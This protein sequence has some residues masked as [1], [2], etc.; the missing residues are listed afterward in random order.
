MGD[1]GM[2]LKGTGM[3]RKDQIIN[4][5]L[6]KRFSFPC[7]SGCLRHSGVK[8]LFLSR[9]LIHTR[10]QIM[11]YGNLSAEGKNFPGSECLET[12]SREGLRL[13]QFTAGNCWSPGNNAECTNH[14]T[15]WSLL[16]SHS[17]WQRRLWSP[18][19]TSLHL[20]HAGMPQPL[21]PFYFFFPPS[22]SCF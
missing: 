10:C 13:A 2:K 3:Q 8:G 20:R 7:S 17:F 6:Y 16:E 4:A 15:S 19:L 22:P 14:E 9:P 11:K 5:A 18:T 21:L 1:R 12:R